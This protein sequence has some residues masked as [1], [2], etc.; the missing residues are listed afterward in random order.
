M[1][2]IKKLS[3]FEFEISLRRLP[4]GVHGC[5][6]MMTLRVVLKGGRAQPWLCTLL[7]WAPLRS[8]KFDAFHPYSTLNLLLLHSYFITL[9]GGFEKD[10]VEEDGA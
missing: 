6:Y 9:P 7:A 5:R 8:M 10:G 2:G 1:C 4:R 3:K